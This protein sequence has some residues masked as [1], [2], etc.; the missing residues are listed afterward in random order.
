MPVSELI[1]VES[2]ADPLL[3]IPLEALVSSPSDEQ[4]K[5]NN[6]RQTNKVPSNLVRRM[7]H[8]ERDFT[9]FSS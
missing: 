8:L 9:G 6:G 4:P 3:S 5:A 1:P 2:E 7:Q